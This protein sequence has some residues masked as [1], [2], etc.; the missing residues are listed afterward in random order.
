VHQW[1]K[2]ALIFLPLISLGDMVRISD[3][4]NL[5]SI[6]LAFSLISSSIYL[7][8]D[9]ND[10]ASDRLDP[11]KSQ[12]PLA[13]GSISVKKVKVIGVILALI[14]FPI[15]FIN[16]TDANRNPIVSLFISYLFLNLLYSHFHLKKHRIIGLIFVALGFAIRFSIGT[17]TLNLAFSTWAFVLIIQLAMFMLSGKRFQNILA[18]AAVDNREHGLQFWLLSMVTFAAF[19]AATYAGFITDPEVV[20]IWGKEA[21]IISILPIGIGLVR[22]VELVIHPEKFPISD[23]TESMT[24]DPFLLMLVFAFAFILLFGRLSA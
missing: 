23:V 11:I 13:N 22:F 14:G 18:S 4:L 19:F 16:T 20:K 3:L 8:N 17:Y 5:L 7:F 1:N 6:A 9:L 10:L 24:K 21:L 12:R 2:Q 15:V